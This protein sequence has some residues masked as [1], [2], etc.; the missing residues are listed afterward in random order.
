[1]RSADPSSTAAPERERV[2]T[3]RITPAGYAPHALLCSEGETAALV[4]VNTDA[5]PHHLVIDKLAL[6]IP[7]LKPG[8]SVT[9]P[10]AH[11]LKGTYLIHS[12]LF[13]PAGADY[14]G[15]LTIR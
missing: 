2:Q 9:L 14:R 6:R 15:T 10:L 13:N 8:E 1:M 5:R 4:I 3:L 11:A 7:V 12:D